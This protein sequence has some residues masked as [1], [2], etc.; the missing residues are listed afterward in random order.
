M[1]IE[2]F[3]I[4]RTIAQAKS[5]TKA[6]KI[7][8]FT[9]PAI[10]SQVKMLEQ[11]FNVA[12][13]ERCNTGVKLT[14]AGRKFYEY[15]ERILAIYAE[16][17]REIANISGNN[18]EFINVGA[19]F[20]AGNYF[21]PASIITFKELHDNVHIRLDI[22]HSID[23]INAI[24]ERSLDL[25]VVEGDYYLDKDLDAYKVQSNEL[26]I[27]S[28]PNNRW[29]DHR[30]IT[31]EELMQ[32]PFIAREEESSIRHFVDSY[33]K[34]L[35]VS[36]DDFNIITEISNFE[37]IKEAVMRNKGIS[38]VPLPVVQR[39]I[40]EGHL[41]RLEVKGV[42]LAWDMRVVV[43][44]NETLTG[45]KEEFLQFLT[46]PNT[47]WKAESDYNQNQKMRFI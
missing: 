26:V 8:N 17:E 1:N 32:I 33:L 2:Q 45:I 23:I 35:G 7:L 31:L 24:K 13:F 3:E 4:F 28:S 11:N 18:R 41:I 46:D 39:E 21:L 34:T 43:R 15:G 14:E 12:L 9:Q 37:A 38:L 19:T 6:A 40:Q 25:G 16:M 47:M 30:V 27:I 44:A 36:F 10:S 29:F 22:G 5:F 20:T 42:K